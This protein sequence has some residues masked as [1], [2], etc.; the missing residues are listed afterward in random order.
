MSTFKLVM[1]GF[2]YTHRKKYSYRVILLNVDV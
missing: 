1:L 2:L